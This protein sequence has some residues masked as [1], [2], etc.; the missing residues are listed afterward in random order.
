MDT[1]PRCT[2]EGVRNYRVGRQWRKR[3]A[4]SVPRNAPSTTHGAT[5]S[6]P[7]RLAASPTH[8]P[9][10]S[11]PCRLTTP[12]KIYFTGNPVSLCHRPKCSSVQWRIHTESS[13][14]SCSSSHLPPAPVP[15]CLL[16]RPPNEPVSPET[17]CLPAP[18]LP[19]RCP[20]SGGS[21]TSGLHDLFPRSHQPSR[22]ERDSRSAASVE[23]N[24]T[25]VVNG[26]KS[27]ASVVGQ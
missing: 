1:P 6:Q 19:P 21:T 15:T 25:D 23:Q 20:T 13:P 24:E 22:L 5:D 14:T 7:F 26:E 4:D 12:W 9:P 18:Y 8:R 16:P 10:D 2:L 27:G 17:R 3:E 11:Q